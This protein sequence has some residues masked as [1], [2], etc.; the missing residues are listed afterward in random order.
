MKQGMIPRKRRPADG[1]VA[2]TVVLLA[3][4][5][6]VS[7]VVAVSFGTTR[8]PVGQVYTVLRYELA[9]RLLGQPIPEAWAPGTA[10]HDVV[11]LIR[12]PRL[13]LAAAVGSSLSLCGVAMQAIVKN[14]LADP[15][16]LG[17]SSGAGLGVTLAVLL[18][19]GTALGG[20]Y[21]GLMAFA[22][23]L[24]ISFA[25]VV[26]ANVGGRAN[27]VKLLLA[28]S[29]LSAVCGAGSQFLLYIH[30]AD[31]AATEILRWTMGS[32]AA[33]DWP[34]NGVM[35]TVAAGGT[36]FFLTQSRTLNLMLLGDETAVTLGTD[37][38][39]YRLVYLTVSALLVG[40]SVYA[41]G[42]IGFV[43]LVV[44]HV[45][46]LLFGTDHR[47]LVP[48]CALSGAL[49]LLWADVLCRTILPGNEIPVGIL[50]AMLG[51]PVFLY[52]MVRRRYGFGGGEA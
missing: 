43:G 14:P 50:T 37:L 21:V 45:V 15:Y 19:V 20:N 44:P 8:L 28:G 26:L 24:A 3:A 30:S 23:A 25:V 22:G 46:R 2:A 38:Y 10:V 6:G 51:A 41:A 40:F 16:I 33:A 34:V 32:L 48:L 7:L 42:A 9:H 31:R 52:L 12:L 13:V 39:R 17:V 47:R 36:A 1:L 5:L 49:F 11:W 18:G 35:L 27:S 4:G 29:A